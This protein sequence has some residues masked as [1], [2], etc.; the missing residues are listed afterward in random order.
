MLTEASACALLGLKCPSTSEEARKAYRSLAKT[1]HPD[2]GGDAERFKELSAAHQFLSELYAGGRSSSKDPPEWEA[3]RAQAQ[4]KAAWDA[5]RDRARAARKEKEREEQHKEQRKTEQAKDTYSGHQ[6]PQRGAPPK[7]TSAETSAETS[8]PEHNNQGP[9][10]V[11]EVEVI[12][13]V[14]ERVTA[15]SDQVAKRLAGGIAKLYRRTARAHFEAGR[16]KSLKL[17]IDLE[18]LLNGKQQ[19]IRVKRFTPCPSCQVGSALTDSRPAAEH[20]MGCAT[21]LGAARVKTAEE[22]SVKIPP[23]A[24]DGH[25]LRVAGKGR[26]GLKGQASGDLYLELIPPDLPQGFKRKGATLLLELGVPQAILRRGGAVQAQTP[27]G[28]ISIPIPAHSSN[29]KQLRISNQ[30]L[31]VWGKSSQGNATIGDL[32]VTLRAR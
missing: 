14:Q 8:E 31:N 13:S 3:K 5:W 18:T 6:G 19:R 22:L 27:R 17:N 1:H 16:D 25:K 21:C 4:Q 32:I 26:S 9:V 12:P 30:G 7:K 29:G 10:E 15:W 20:A 24:D 2:V 23:G 11:V 28:T